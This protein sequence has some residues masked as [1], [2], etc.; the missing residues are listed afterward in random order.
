MTDTKVHSVPNLP[1][2]E[3][4]YKYKPDVLSGNEVASFSENEQTNQDSILVLY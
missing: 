4:I 1:R 2:H 3:K